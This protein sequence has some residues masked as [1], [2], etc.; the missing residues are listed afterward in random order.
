M[1]VNQE[2]SF[3]VQRNGAR[4]V[5]DAKVHTPAGSAEECY[6]TELDSGKPPPPHTHTHNPPNPPFPHT[7]THMHAYTHKYT[8]TG[9]TDNTVAPTC[10]LKKSTESRVPGRQTDRFL[11]RL[12]DMC[13]RLCSFLPSRESLK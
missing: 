1:K 5:V 9:H 8:H 10:S 6:V 13:R 11:F 4:G 3:M 2:A 7:H 12:L